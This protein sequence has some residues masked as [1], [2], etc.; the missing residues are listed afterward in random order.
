[1]KMVNSA[2]ILAL[3]LL[4]SGCVKP[5]TPHLTIAIINLNTIVPDQGPRIKACFSEEMI[6]SELKVNIYITENNDWSSREDL[7]PYT[8]Y[9]NAQLVGIPGTLSRAIPDELWQASSNGC[10]TA[11]VGNAFM[12]TQDWVGHNLC[13]FGAIVA[14]A[15]YKKGAWNAAEIV[16]C[17]I[18]RVN[19]P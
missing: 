17:D 3:G 16:E 18:S 14:V 19:D 11:Y 7:P 8:D 10:H 5:I 1:M 12:N 15:N 6:L 4:I 13:P 9:F 2:I